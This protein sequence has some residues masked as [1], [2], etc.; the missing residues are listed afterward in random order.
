M[1]NPIDKQVK[2]DQL[3]LDPNNYRLIDEKEEK[4]IEDS[5]A[6]GLQ[7]ETRR[8]LEKQRLG[9][10]KDSM[11]NNGFLE[12]ERIVI[13]LLKTSEN[14]AETDETKKKYIVVE[15]NRRTAALKSLQEFNKDNPRTL[16]D[17]L[18]KKFDLMNVIFID[19]DE[20]KLR[21][22]S[23]TLMGVRHVSGP[24]KWDGF[25]SAKLIDDLYDDGH[26]FTKIGEI[27]GITNREVGRRFRGYQAFTQMRDTSG[28]EDKVEPRHYG[29]LLEFLSASKQGRSWLEWNDNSYRFDNSDNLT[30]VYQAITSD[31]ERELEIRNPAD[32]RKFVSLLEDSQ[33]KE[34]LEQGINIHDMPEPSEFKKVGRKVQRITSFIKFIE[35]SNFSTEETE[36]LQDLH[37]ILV[38]KEGV[39]S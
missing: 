25:Q 19:G 36:M 29:L 35:N 4:I 11:K 6:E 37:S 39:L 26:S 21:T 23:A 20:K 33:Y 34:E 16:N 10:L 27:L 14:I 15:G 38:S 2:L 28:F 13:R 17:S 5:K 22:Y 3:I 31:E 24:K 8:R 18:I 30:R 1:I 7:V 12:M 32:A 9:E